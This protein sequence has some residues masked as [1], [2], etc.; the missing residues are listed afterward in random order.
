MRALGQQRL[1]PACLP[2]PMQRVLAAV[3]HG[4][5]LLLAGILASASLQAA[6][7]D[8][9]VVGVWEIRLT[10]G[11]ATVRLIWEIAA[12]GQYRQRS[13]PPGAISEHQGNASFADG[14]WQ[15]SA[16][17]DWT[18]GGTYEVPDPTTLVATGRLGEGIWKRTATSASI[19]PAPAAAP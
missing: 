13:E 15:L 8:P 6:E 11:G 17:A 2:A 18:D 19:P 12:D 10:E 3:R 1:W 5:W 14:R 7:V 9:R 4:L 16:A